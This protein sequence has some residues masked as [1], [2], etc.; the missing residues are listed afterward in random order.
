MKSSRVGEFVRDESYDD[1]LKEFNANISSI[2]MSPRDEGIEGEYRPVFVVG[3][4]RS[5]TTLLTQVL[6]AT[7]SFA[8]PSN[9]IARFYDNPALGERVSQLL[10]P[11]IGCDTKQFES[12]MGRTKSW[13]DPNEFG[14]F[15]SRFFDF[16]I[17]HEVCREQVLNSA[18]ES[19]KGEVSSWQSEAAKPLL[20]KCMI[21]N[22][23][24]DILYEMYPNALFVR[25][26]RSFHDVVKSMVKG[27]RL[28][29]GSDKNW[30][31][32]RPKNWEKLNEIVDPVEKTVAQVASVEKSLDCFWEKL[33]D[34][35]KMLCKY[36]D[37]CES[38]HHWLDDLSI[39]LDIKVSSSGIP[40]EFVP[41]SSIQ[42]EESIINYL[43]EY[44]LND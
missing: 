42:C 30:F 36:D 1:L 22:Y 9:L 38:P 26:Q 8:Y 40:K 4:P 44:G 16:S 15:W 25:T 33:P 31:S 19:F 20:L 37:F 12:N 21:M 13:N 24:L 39:K 2:K 29:T 32:C 10:A 18:L 3:L 43:K 27:R 28:V 5:G 6:A 14:F 35:N 34:A 23:S 41:N 17:H 11:V 7:N